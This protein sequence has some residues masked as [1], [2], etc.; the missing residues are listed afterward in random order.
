MTSFEEFIFLKLKKNI[1]HMFHFS[2]NCLLEL[3]NLKFKVISF[4]QEK[5]TN[6]FHE[7][8]MIITRQS[9]MV[10]VKLSVSGHPTYLKNSRGR[11]HCAYS[12]C[13]YMC[14]WGVDPK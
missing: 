6:S 11:T 4:Y 13:G 10:L 9:I 14:V 7:N 3:I 12:R 2:H 8:V 5:Q 1:L